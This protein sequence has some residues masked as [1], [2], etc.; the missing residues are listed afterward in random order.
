MAAGGRARPETNQADYTDSNEFMLQ[1]AYDSH[2]AGPEAYMEVLHGM[3]DE[4]WEESIDMAADEMVERSGIAKPGEPLFGA[5]H[6][7]VVENYTIEPPYGHY[8][9][10]DMKVNIILGTPEERDLDFG[11]IDAAEATHGTFLASVAEEMRN[12]PNVMGAVTVLTNL[13]MSQLG[14]ALCPQD[15]LTVPKDAA[16]GIF[17][18]WVGGGSGLDIQLERDLDIP[19]DMRFDV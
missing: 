14:Q 13:S 16:I 19:P 6:D 3:V 1:T 5:A 9:D 11:S 8:M 7:Y 17:A 18:P 2:S 4:A 15:V 10:E 12:F